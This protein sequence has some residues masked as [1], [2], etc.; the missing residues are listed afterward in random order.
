MYSQTRS[1][2]ILQ[3]TMNGN[4]VSVVHYIFNQWGTPTR[5]LFV[6]QVNSKCSTYCSREALAIAPR[7]TLSYS[8]GQTNSTMLFL[9]YYSYLGYYTKLDEIDSDSDCPPLAQLI[10]VPQL[11][12]HVIM[13]M[14]S[15][16]HLPRSADPVQ[17]QKKTSQSTCITPQNVISGWASA[18][19]QIYS[20]A[21]R[22]ILSRAGKTPPDI[23]TGSSGDV[24]HHGLNKKALHQNQWGSSS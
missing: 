7:G 19:D 1:A 9:H 23:G 18:L 8:P 17:R 3:S 21:V 2:D 4:F 14:D 12:P 20:S 22:N 16:P 6:S 13:L 5:D 15:H 11:S 10:L 24:F